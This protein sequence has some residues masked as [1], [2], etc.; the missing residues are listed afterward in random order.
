MFLKAAEAFRQQP[1]CDTFYSCF[2][3]FLLVLYLH[4]IQEATGQRSHAHG[5]IH[6]VVL[7]RARTWAQ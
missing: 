4:I 2:Y 6:G 5:V 7:C 3:I 1:A